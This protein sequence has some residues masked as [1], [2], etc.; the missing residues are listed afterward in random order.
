LKF[1]LDTNICIYLINKKPAQVFEKFK[2]HSVG[3]IGISAITFAELAFGVANSQRPE[4]NELLL[5]EFLAPLEIL[6]YP[7]DAATIY[8]KLRSDL[9]RK[10]ALLGPLDM[11]I[12]SH[13]LFLRST[14]ITN[15]KSEFSRVP[16]LRVERWI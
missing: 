12:A 1:L 3:D 16:E 4:Q 15:N 8:G 9:K 5:Q 13:A 7:A 6:D 14:L 11:L 10:G 2:R